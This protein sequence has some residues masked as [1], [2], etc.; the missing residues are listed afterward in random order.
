MTR[1]LAVLAAVC[2]SVG[3]VSVPV[4]SLA[5]APQLPA[6]DPFY[7][8]AGSLKGI[9]PGTIL[10][11][12]AVSIGELGIQTPIAATQVLYRT[13]GEIG[14]PT[15]T[16]A[17][18]IKPLLPSATTKIV[19]FQQAY[20]ALGTE[21]D[22]SYT[23]RGGNPTDATAA[24]EDAFIDT[25]IAEGYTVVDSDYE[26]ETLDYG[27]GQ[28]SGYGTLDAIRAAE[29]LLKAP[30]AS[31]PIGIVGYSG[32]AIASEYAAELAPTYS[33]EL[34]IV[35]AAIG[36]IPTDFAHTLNY[37]SGSKGWAGAIPDV[38]SG[39]ARGFRINFPT[40]LSSY[41][42]T[43]VNQV[44][45][46]CL[47][48]TAYPGLTFQQ[49][50]KPQ[51]QDYTKIPIFVHIFNKMIMSTSGTPHEPLLLVNGNSDGIGDGV[52]IAK[53]VQE[54]AYTYCRRG[55]PVQFHV[56][57]GLDHIGAAV[58]FEPMAV[59]FLTQRL[60]G[61]PVTDGCSSITPGNALTP[62]PVPP[63]VPSK[64]V[65]HKKTAHKKRH[66]R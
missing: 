20:D 3:A 2:A 29:S 31:T 58:P 64:K 18:I 23:L 60:S 62:L 17:T 26:G 50:L 35:G 56:F 39:L 43:V 13:T 6:N 9:A 30:A 33:P 36:G 48:P 5:A 1:K 47:V 59:A 54:L 22:T 66:R 44:A 25:Y 51:Y 7:I 21:C 10:R 11:T 12:R 45:N 42:Q 19:S 14:Q 52:M 49:M 61:L 24:L 8:Y 28:E 55:V 40:Y 32:G 63:S 27:S 38:L 65:A 34:H 41:G 46:G 4:A 37:I 57:K 15:V 53:D 16:V